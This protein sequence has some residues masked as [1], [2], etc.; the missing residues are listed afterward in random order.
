LSSQKTIFLKQVQE[1]RVYKISQKEPKEGIKLKTGYQPGVIGRVAQMHALYYHEHWNFGSFFEA[2]I[3]SEMGEFIQRY[4]ENRDFLQTAV[5]GGEIE[6]SI[7]IDGLH[8]R[9][10]GAHLRWFI[11]SD[12]LRS[13]GAGK[14]L[15]KEAIK[16]C[17]KNGY[18]MVY[19]WTFEGLDAARHI[20]EQAGFHLQR[21]K[22]GEQWGVQVKE[23]CFEAVLD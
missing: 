7:I 11:L 2:K 3:A 9:E 16:F 6:G 5:T 17:R 20:Y 21:E 12:A 23:Q 10:K 18:K 13:Q 4:E 22:V 19:L 8:A 1:Y 14:L 15:V